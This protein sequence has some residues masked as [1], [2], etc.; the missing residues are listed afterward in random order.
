MVQLPGAMWRI[1]AQEFAAALKAD[2]LLLQRALAYANL[3]ID[4]LAQFAG[5]NRLHPV[6]ERCA[7]WLLM[8]HDAVEGDTLMLTHEYLA[9]MLGVRRP[10]V[11]VAARGLDDAG[12]IEYHRGRILIDR[13]GLEGASCECYGVAANAV[14]QLL[15]YGIPQRT[16]GAPYPSARRRPLLGERLRQG[17]LDDEQ[18]VKARDAEEAPDVAVRRNDVA[19][20][21][22]GRFVQAHEEGEHRRVDI[23]DGPSS[24]KK[25]RSAPPCWRP[26][27]STRVA[28]RWTGRIR[29]KVELMS[30]PSLWYD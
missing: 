20:P 21:L 1:R 16:L 10:G 23:P 26:R 22:S 11:S 19:N 4:T 25:S 30:A 15:R 6:D 9:T 5:C 28:P 29:R 18:R 2:A 12:F 27:V 13:R 8:A 24:P 17:V 3:I 7:R 14:E